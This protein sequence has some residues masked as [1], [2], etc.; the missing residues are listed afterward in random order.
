[1][2]V[3][4]EFHFFQCVIVKKLSLVSENGLG[5]EN[6]NQPTSDVIK[7]SGML[8]EEL[9]EMEREWLRQQKAQED[10]DRELAKKLQEELDE[11]NRTRALV[12]RRKGS[13]DEYQLRTNKTK[14]QSTIED[15]FQR[16]VRKSSPLADG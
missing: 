16:S 14:N 4:R 1:M 10:A 5:D 7:D 2:K 3:K 8:A 12:N 11:E 13:K 9:M 15:S 6:H